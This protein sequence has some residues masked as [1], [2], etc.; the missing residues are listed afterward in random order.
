M[1]STLPVFIDQASDKIE[2]AASRRIMAALTTPAASNKVNFTGRKNSVHGSA[3]L[4]AGR[5]PAGAE[6]NR[7]AVLAFL[8]RCKA[9]K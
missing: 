1:L 3:T 6:E 4:R 2:L 8:A 5:Y 7:Q 9:V